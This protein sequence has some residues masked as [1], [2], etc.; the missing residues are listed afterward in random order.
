[1]IESDDKVFEEPSSAEQP[2]QR[3]ANCRLPIDDCG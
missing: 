2:R 3:T 1:V